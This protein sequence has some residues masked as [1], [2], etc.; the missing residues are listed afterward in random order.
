MEWLDIPAITHNTYRKYVIVNPVFNS[1]VAL[2]CI[3]MITD[4]LKKMLCRI[5]KRANNG[6]KVQYALSALVAD[7]MVWLCDVIDSFYWL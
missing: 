6:K 1:V 2:A 3:T 5:L 4:W 7:H